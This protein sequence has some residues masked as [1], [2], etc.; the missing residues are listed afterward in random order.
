MSK[1]MHINIG[2][3]SCTHCQDVIE[4]GL[5]SLKGVKRASADYVKETAD[6]EYDE[7]VISED[8][9]FKKIEKL[10]YKVLGKTDSS[11]V[12]ITDIISTLAIIQAR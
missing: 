7:R 4:N 11:P 6:V 9:I 8:K 2:G 5:K 1:K 3:M 10:G 12:N